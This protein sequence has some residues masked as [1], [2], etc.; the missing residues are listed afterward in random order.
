MVVERWRERWGDVTARL[1]D[2]A[3]GYGEGGHGADSCGSLRRGCGQ[4]A[5][6][7]SE[8]GDVRRG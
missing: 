8:M 1:G 6:M 3:E 7:Q 4:G 2:G 5:V